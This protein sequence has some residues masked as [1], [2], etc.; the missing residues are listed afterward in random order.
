MY[1]IHFNYQFVQNQGAELYVRLPWAHGV[2]VDKIKVFIRLVTL[3]EA[4]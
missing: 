1:T 2:K 4:K 3:L